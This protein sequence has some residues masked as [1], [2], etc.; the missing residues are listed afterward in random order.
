MRLGGS[1]RMNRRM[2]SKQR[3]MEHELKDGECLV[4]D[5]IE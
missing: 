2:E 5:G 3:W 4:Y 1:L